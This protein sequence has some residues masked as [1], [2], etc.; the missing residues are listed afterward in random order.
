MSPPSRRPHRSA[1]RFLLQGS[2]VCVR[3]L[4]CRRKGGEGDFLVPP[5]HRAFR[6]PFPWCFPDRLRGHPHAT[7]GEDQP[8]DAR[9]GDDATG[10][11]NDRIARLGER[12]A[13]H[14]VAEWRGVSDA[15]V[16]IGR[17][18]GR[19]ARAGRVGVGLPLGRCIARIDLLGWLAGE[20]ADLHGGG[21]GVVRLGARLDVCRHDLV[22][23][24]G[25]GLGGRLGRLGAGRRALLG[26]AVRCDGRAAVG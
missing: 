24:V 8:D 25:H 19:G 6:V 23:T 17:G 1:G 2:L 4:A 21:S 13:R 3:F 16:G 15:L 12:P 7:P 20:P 10:H 9:A 5:R 26:V 14:E 22:G 11:D 18:A